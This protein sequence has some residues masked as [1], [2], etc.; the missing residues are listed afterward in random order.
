MFEIG[1]E[2]REQFLREQLIYPRGYMIAEMAKE[3][4]G[5]VYKKYQIVQ[6]NSEILHK[7]TP[8][9]HVW[10]YDDK[11]ML[12]P[13]KQY[14]ARISLTNP[15]VYL[16]G[17]KLPKATNKELQKVMSPMFRYSKHGMNLKGSVWSLCVYH[18]NGGIGLTKI[19]KD[20]QQPDYTQLK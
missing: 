20:E 4:G 2:I 7:D 16:L 13:E 17:D 14:N 11:G 3:V 19:G 15:P 8:H 5:R 9:F 18:W 6:K 12:I 1:E 10:Q